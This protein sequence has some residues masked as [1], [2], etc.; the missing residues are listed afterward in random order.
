VRGPEEAFQ[1]GAACELHGFEGRPAAEEV[2]K[3]PGSFLLQPLQD[4]REGVFEGTGHT[5]GETHVVADQAPAV[6]D[7]L[8]QG[9]HGGA[10]GAEGGELV[11]VCEEQC[12]LE[13]GIGGGIFGPA[14]GQRFA[15][16]RHGEWSDGTEHEA[17]IGAQRGHDGPFRELQAHRDGWAVASRAEGL[18]PGVHR[19]RTMV[20]A[21]QLP[22]CG[23][24]GLE[25][26]I[27]CRISPVEAHKGRKGFGCLW[28]HVG[29][30]R[31]W[32]SGA[33]GQACW[34]SAKA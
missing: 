5:V 8:R 22:W 27:V 31:V 3:E 7:E 30:P 29:S 33:K 6:R 18:A 9:A 10:V 21:Q 11:P 20:K 28:L 24:S 12:E 23:A 15:V 25:A 17:I 16:L 19:F 14:R 2:A 32:Y 4:V 34:R 26:D 13:C 1:S